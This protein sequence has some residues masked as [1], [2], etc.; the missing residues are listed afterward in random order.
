MLVHLADNLFREQPRLTGNAD[1]DVR[2]HV[3][4]HVEQGEHIV[5]GIPALQMFALLHQLVLERQQIRH[6][7]G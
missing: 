1:Q 7:V 2:F 4:H 6:A 3:A 5:S